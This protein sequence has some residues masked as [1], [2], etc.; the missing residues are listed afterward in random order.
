MNFQLSEISRQ[1]PIWNFIVI[2]LSGGISFFDCIRF[3]RS[4]EFFVQSMQITQQSLARFKQVSLN[5][6]RKFFVKYILEIYDFSF[7]D[8]RKNFNRMIV[9]LFPF[10]VLDIGVFYTL[11]FYCY[12]HIVN[13]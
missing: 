10:E 11:I 1:K 6:E 2:R 13:Y 3:F 8:Y 5:L 4:P 9:T 7:I 12:Y